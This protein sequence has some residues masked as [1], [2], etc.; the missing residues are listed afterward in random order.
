MTPRTTISLVDLAVDEGSGTASVTATIANAPTDGPVVV[1]LDNGATITFAVGATSATSTAFAIQ[2][3]DVYL[4]GETLTLNAS[5]TSGG[6]EFENLTL[7]PTVEVVVS[8]TIDTVTVDLSATETVAED[9]TI[10]YTATL[11]GGVAN[12]D[13]TVTLANGEVITIAAG[14]A[15]GTVDVAAP[16]DD[17]YVTAAITNSIASAVEANAGTAGAL[18]NLAVAG[19]TSVSTDV[20]END[21]ETTIQSC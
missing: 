8:D 2:G 19:D 6:S 16:T 17:A 14:D 1:T 21:T 18:E 12:N 13:I 5:V 3:D 15:S 4:D 9:G 7:D 20:T 10:T 11:T